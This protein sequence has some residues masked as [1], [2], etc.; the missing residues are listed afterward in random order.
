MAAKQ[1]WSVY[2]LLCGDGSLYC[3]ISTN[4]ERRLAQH[5]GEI[6]GG[7]KYTRSRRPLILMGVLECGDKS[8]ALKLEHKIKSLPRSRKL[9]LFERV[10]NA[11][12]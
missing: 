2:L 11:G 8:A 1:I 6:Q 3:G 10:A 4:P 5:N 12:I 9:D 7:A